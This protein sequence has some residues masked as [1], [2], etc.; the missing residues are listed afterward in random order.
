[1]IETILKYG[2]EKIP[3]I[4]LRLLDD[5]T[6]EIVDGKQRLLTA[7]TPY[8]NNEYGLQGVYNENLQGYRLSDIYDEYPMTYSAFMSCK[9][10]LEIMEDMSDEDAIT[11]FIQINSSGVNMTIGE[12]IHA[13]QGT[14]I[15]KILDSLKS[16]N[17]WG[18]VTRKMRYNIYWH[19]SRMLLFVRDYEK[20]A[21]TIH[22][23]TQPQLLNE[24][25]KYRSSNVPKRVV[26]SV[27]ETF[28]FLNKIFKK[29]DF[30]V[31]IAEF[32]S[33]FLYT[34]INIS[35]LKKEEGNYGQFISEL[36]Y[37]IY[38]YSDDRIFSVFKTRHNETGFKYTPQYY[39][40]YIHQVDMM[41]RKFKNGDGWDDI[42]RVPVLQG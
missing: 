39:H 3:T 15:L 22:C 28:D 7:I 30:K 29:F 5:G 32:F 34:H 16:H 11:Y 10:P 13:M 38:N 23:Y 27:K 42:R 21:G 41:F 37:H 18:Y 12:K 4:T 8:I 36:Y 19:L 14:S 40:G 35:S 20:N 1:M 26:K 25:D 17:V 31:T 9:I 2:G 6:Y 33:I 24:L